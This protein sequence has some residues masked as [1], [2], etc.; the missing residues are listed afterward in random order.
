MERLSEQRELPSNGSYLFGFDLMRMSG[1][2]C[3]RIWLEVRA[4]S[5]CGAS[6]LCSAK[7]PLACVIVES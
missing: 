6:P 3:G 1:A 4:S 2:Y 7:T 5:S